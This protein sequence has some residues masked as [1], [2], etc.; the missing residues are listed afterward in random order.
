[1]NKRQKVLLRI[2]LTALLFAAAVLVTHFIPMAWYFELLI[3]VPVYLLIAYDILFKA[4]KGMRH[5]QILDE[6]LLMIIATAGAFVVREYP[7]A[8][9]V[10]WLYQIGELF[11][12]YAVGKSRK[13]IGALMD[14]RPDSACVLRDGKECVVSP[15]EV[16][17]GETVVVRPGERVPL[18]GI[19]LEGSTSLDTAAL[20][21]ESVPQKA[22]AGDSVMSGCINLSGVVKMRCEKEFYDSTVSK[23]LDLV[24]NASSKKAKAENFI[25]KFAKYYTPIVVGAALLLAVVPSLVTG[26]WS[27]WVYRALSFL[28]ASCPCALV[29][30]VPLSFFGGIGGASAEGVLVKGGNYLELL[31]RADVFVMDKTG[32]VTKGV[33]AV[34]SVTPESNREEILR[35]A[36]IAESGSTHPIALSI[37]RA[38]PQ[39]RADGWQIE[40]I[41]GKGVRAVLGG[42]TILAGNDKLMRDAGIAHTGETG[43]GSVVY[44]AKDG[45]FVGSVRIADAVK[46]GSAQAVLALKADGC[47]MYMLT[48]D[49][50]QTAKAVAESVGIDEYKAQLLPGDKVAELEKILA[51]KRKK[52]VVAFVGDG[53]N[54]APVLTRADVG[55]A[56]GGLGSDSAIEAADV[57]LMHDDL[58]SIPVAKKIA[59]RTMRV[60][61]QNIVFALVVK[62][63]VLVLSALGITNMWVA[64]FA[65]VGVMV[66]AVLNAMRCIRRVTKKEKKTSCVQD[67]PVP[68]EPSVS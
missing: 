47:R 40:E 31:S 55:V 20:T 5:G 52:S 26:E 62:A 42:E 19:L 67:A 48:G 41:A 39:V 25:T 27:V 9:L 23:I 24:E 65:D 32:T 51:A 56:M 54:D 38:A 15:E 44:V 49:N 29:I 57:V 1:M 37:V 7:E 17:L 28:V 3:F 6:N 68:R 11:Q 64:I 30:S 34:Q 63:A 46:E 50:A 61:L 33:F 13:S 14:I 60:V 8:I 22:K 12:S 21:G 4:A 59:R 53:I 18:D 10:M 35:L 36:A 16:A 45:V 58:N 2:I 66:L 43:M